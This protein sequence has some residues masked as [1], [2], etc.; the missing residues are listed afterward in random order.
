MSSNSAEERNFP[1]SISILSS[2][3]DAKIK[4]RHAVIKKGGLHLRG[5]DHLDDK[6]FRMLLPSREERT[7]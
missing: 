1:F 6:D 3:W 4:V 2:T 5:G 7:I